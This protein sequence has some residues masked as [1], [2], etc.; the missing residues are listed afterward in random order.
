M[1]KTLA[2]LATACLLT[3]A[4][5]A[6]IGTTYYNPPAVAVLQQMLRQY[7]ADGARAE[8]QATLDRMS[9]IVQ[10]LQMQ[11]YMRQMQAE[12][13]LQY[14]QMLRQQMMMQQQPYGYASP[15]V[16]PNQPGGAAYNRRVA[17]GQALGQAIGQALGDR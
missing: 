1:K 6:Q 5:A 3:L 15:Y 9:A 8:I 11:N 16:N 13:Q 2:V 7:Q 10:Q 12:Q 14:Q 17:L 4:A